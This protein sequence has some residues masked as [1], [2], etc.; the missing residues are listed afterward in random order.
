MRIRATSRHSLTRDI[1]QAYLVLSCFGLVI[2]L[3]IYGLP[4]LQLHPR[5]SAPKAAS[6]DAP[7]PYRGSVIIDTE[8][9]NVCMESVLDNRTGSMREIGYVKCD[10]V[11]TRFAEPEPKSTSLARMRS[12]AKTFRHQDD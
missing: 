1:A 4:S 12:V 3:S 7:S 8:R 9:K 2:S 5:E 11:L 6:G 10:A